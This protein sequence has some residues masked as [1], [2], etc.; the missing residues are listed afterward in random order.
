METTSQL[1]CQFW[2]SFL[3]WESMENLHTNT[4]THNH[5]ENEYHIILNFGGPH[6][7]PTQ[8]I[9]CME[10]LLMLHR[11][12]IK[13]R[14]RLFTSKDNNFKFLIATWYFIHFLL[15]SEKKDCNTNVFLDRWCYYKG[16]DRKGLVILN[17]YH[18]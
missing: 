6:L 5:Y 9:A 16:V 4:L 10:N 2:L 15:W 18:I 8:N 11:Y 14:N 13:F 3:I 12:H 1:P 17:A 7:R